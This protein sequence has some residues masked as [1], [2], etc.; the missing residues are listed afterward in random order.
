MLSAHAPTRANSN[1]NGRALHKTLFYGS[2]PFWT[3][4]RNIEVLIVLHDDNYSS[5]PQD[6]N[7]NSPTTT[8]V[9]MAALPIGIEDTK[10]KCFE[11]ICFDAGTRIEAPRVYVGFEQLN[12]W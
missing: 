12:E 10:K 8:T 5:N 4:L 3:V 7:T 1:T 2:R 11:I 9:S 6:P